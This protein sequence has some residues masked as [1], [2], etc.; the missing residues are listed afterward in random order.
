MTG[1]NCCLEKQ[2]KGFS[3]DVSIR[4]PAGIT[5]LFGPSGSGKSMTLQ[6]LAGLL[7]PDRGRVVLDGE[8]LYDSEERVTVPPQKRSFGYVFQDAALFPHMTVMKNVLYGWPRSGGR[9][10]IGRAREML[11]RFHIR[12]MEDRYPCQ[13]SGGQKQRVALARALMR[14]PRALL[15]DE[16]F[17]ALDIPLRAELRGFLSGLLEELRIPVILVT[18]DPADV[19]ALADRVLFYKSGKI[20]T[21]ENREDAIRTTGRRF[22]QD[23]DFR[24]REALFTY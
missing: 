24:E 3:L 13:I 23:M 14:R 9:E 20:V 6:L 18:H 1:L 22:E 8:I 15:L 7:A 5:V 16:P 2:I 12:G 17:S 10:G 11:E 21:V 19:S 4:S